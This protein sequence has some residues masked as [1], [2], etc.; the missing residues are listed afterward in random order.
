MVSKIPIFGGIAAAV[1][2]IIILLFLAPPGIVQEEYSLNVDPTKEKQSLFIMARVS[3]ENTGTKPLTNVEIN[4]GDGDKL[5]L[6]TLKPGQSEIISPPNG[7]S[8]QYVIV[9]SNEGVYVSK[10]YR[11]PIAMPGM[12]GS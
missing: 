7:N 2:G 3:L 5:Y 4:F 9:T 8:L 11:E 1:A 6:G 12:M 10:V